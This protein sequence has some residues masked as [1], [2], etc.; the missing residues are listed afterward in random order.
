MDNQ[1]LVDEQIDA[2]TE[3]LERLRAAG[4]DVAV[5]FW[6]FTT[7]EQRWYLYIASTMVDGEGLAVAHRKVN[8]ELCKLH[9]PWIERAELRLISTAD[10]IAQNALMYEHERVPTTY[11]GRLLGNQIVEGVYIYPK[12][13]RRR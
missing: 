1:A 7:E 4:I 6:A 11:G 10:P 2:G 8:T 3:L 13:A 5:A 9:Q 12:G